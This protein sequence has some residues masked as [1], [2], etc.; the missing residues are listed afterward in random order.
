M[1]D[2]AAKHVTDHG[3]DLANGHDARKVLCAAFAGTS[4]M[5]L[6]PPLGTTRAE[7]LLQRATKLRMDQSI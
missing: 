2:T 3:S 5:G 4:D 7:G 6:L 1:R